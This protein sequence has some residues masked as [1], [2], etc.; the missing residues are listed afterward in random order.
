MVE[1]YQ[2]GTQMVGFVSEFPEGSREKSESTWS[3]GQLKMSF[4]VKSGKGF[5]LM[6]NKTPVPTDMKLNKFGHLELSTFSR[7]QTF[8]F[9]RASNK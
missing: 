5:Y 4:D 7:S 6:G 2:A 8:S 3:K 9:A 1:I